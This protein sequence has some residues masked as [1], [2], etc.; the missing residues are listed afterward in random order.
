MLLVTVLRHHGLGPWS[1][2]ELLSAVGL[3]S[4]VTVDY[5]SCWLE[6]VGAS[7]LP[8]INKNNARSPSKTIEQWLTSF[9]CAKSIKILNKMKLVWSLTR[10]RSHASHESFHTGDSWEFPEIGGLT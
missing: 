9:C 5:F 6:L 2:W 1:L 8:V 3:H 4:W 7:H 10:G